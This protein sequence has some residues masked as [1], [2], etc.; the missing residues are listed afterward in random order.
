MLKICIQTSYD[1]NV[2]L[3][4]KSYLP[5]VYGTPLSPVVILLPQTFKLFGFRI[6]RFWAY[7]MK[8]I[9]ESRRAH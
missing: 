1:Q 2:Q 8:V 5:V 4:L 6:F 3:I 7:M 9:P